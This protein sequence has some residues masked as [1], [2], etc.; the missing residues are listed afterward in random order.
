MQS[1]NDTLSFVASIPVRL[2]YSLIAGKTVTKVCRPWLL[3]ERLK[4]DDL[5]AREQVPLRVAARTATDLKDE[6]RGWC[7]SGLPFLLPLTLALN[8]APRL[9]PGLA[10]Q[11]TECS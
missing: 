2:F 5:H 3:V 8:E 10:L 7:P 11:G 9:L 1:A 4:Q 6:E